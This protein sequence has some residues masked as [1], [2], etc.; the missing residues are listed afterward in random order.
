M[1]Y[2]L[3]QEQQKLPALCSSILS[4]QFGISKSA[5]KLVIQYNHPL[6]YHNT[7]GL[8]VDTQQYVRVE[9]IEDLKEIYFGQKFR[10]VK[11]MILGGGSNVLFTR[12]WLGLI[13]H[14]AIPEIKKVSES[15]DHIQ[16]AAGAGESW[17][18]LVLWAVG[19]GYGGIENLSLIPGTV[20][21]A[22]MQN[23]GAYGVEV[24]DVF[25]S[26]EALELKTGKVVRFYKEDCLFGY[27][28][29]IFKK[30]QKGNYIITRV[31]LTLQKQSEVNTSY[32]AI[33]TTLAEMNVDNPTIADVSEAVI[34]I[35]QYKLPDPAEIGNAGSFFKNPII[36]KAHFEA[37]EVLHPEIPH[38]TISADEEKIPAGW[39]IEKCG[40]KGYRDGNIGVHDKQ[41]L[42]LVNHGSGKGMDIRKLSMEIRRSINKKFQIELEAEVN[43][44]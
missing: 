24:K 16:V 22:P 38:Y 10:N 23:I 32:G 43:M 18:G 12:N 33:E 1:R 17:H 3:G 26:L 28:S 15:E 35:R 31:F 20:G 6:K 27:R 40:W 36:E 14:M 19:H 30:E 2:F 5:P 13:A 9:S 11:K 4:C 25:H 34:S 44:V 39:L 21:A 29:S 42:V 41:A 8:D 37:L 7:F